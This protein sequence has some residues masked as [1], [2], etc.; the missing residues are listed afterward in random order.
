[1]DICIDRKRGPLVLEVNARPGLEIQNVKG[2]GL[3]DLFLLLEQG[4]EAA[5]P[6]GVADI[7]SGQ[8]SAQG[9]T[10]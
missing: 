2:R 10:T 3:R 5:E 7:R 4:Q 8:L 1:M 9:K 6:T